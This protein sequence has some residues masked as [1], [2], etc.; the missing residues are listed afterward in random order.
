MLS[1]MKNRKHTILILAGIAVVLYL[2]VDIAYL[3]LEINTPPP[4]TPQQA[5][6]GPQAADMTKENRL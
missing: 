2:A 1:F 4:E 5:A 6:A 3:V